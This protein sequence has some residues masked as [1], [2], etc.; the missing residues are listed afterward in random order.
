MLELA[1]IGFSEEE[2]FRISASIRRLAD[3]YNTTS[4]RF[5]G[6]ILSRGKDYYVA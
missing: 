2:S 1:G 3:K 5:W 4:I 6:K